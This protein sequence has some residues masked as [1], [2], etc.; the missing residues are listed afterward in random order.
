MLF[1]P[2][3][4]LDS[5]CL[6]I[7]SINVRGVLNFLFRITDFSIS[8]PVSVNFYFMSFDSVNRLYQ[9]TYSSLMMICSL[10]IVLYLSCLFNAFSIEVYSVSYTC[11]LSDAYSFR[12]IY[13]F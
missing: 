4:I 1:G 11:H 13:F 5:F 7:L 10:I 9:H 3:I 8:L 6:N 2:S 12:A